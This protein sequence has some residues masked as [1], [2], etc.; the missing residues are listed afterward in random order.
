VN[1]LRIRKSLHKFFWLEERSRPSS[2][3][4]LVDSFPSYEAAHE[5]YVAE[6]QTPSLVKHYGHRNRISWVFKDDWKLLIWV[7]QLA[8]DKPF[9]ILENQRELSRWA[10][11]HDA[12]IAL[13]VRRDERMTA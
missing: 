9:V 7:D 5:A 1:E 8:R 12:R 2:N 4:L 3:W 11:M 13:L 6:K 10:H